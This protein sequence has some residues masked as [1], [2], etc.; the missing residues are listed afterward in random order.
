MNY[1]FY[2]VVPLGGPTLIPLVFLLLRT[3]LDS[4][5]AD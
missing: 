3:L 5:V 4:P 1:I 2:K